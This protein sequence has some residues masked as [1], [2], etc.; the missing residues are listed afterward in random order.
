[1]ISIEDQQKLLL[2]V[3]NK[4]RENITVY[5]IGGTAMMFWGYKDFTKDIDLV[6]TNET[7]RDSFIDA[8][9]SIGYIDIGAGTI[10][11]TRKH[12]PEMFTLGDERFDLFLVDVIDFIF[13]ES[14]QKRAESTHQFGNN[15]ILKIADPHDIIL[16]K[17]AANRAK[18]A[19]DVRKI[20]EKDHINWDIIITE[21][22]NQIKL[23]K[24]GSAFCL[25]EFCEKLKNEL[26]VNIPIEVL[27]VLW[28]IVVQQGKERLIRK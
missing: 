1:M 7:D 15:L 5:A 20:L 14:M 2:S 18:D 10:Y 17:C 22:K 6:F 3:A 24:E 9:K 11:G 19:D 13:S 8:I 26:N 28:G 12:Q 21:V 23:G 16:M 27:D 4:L 25:G